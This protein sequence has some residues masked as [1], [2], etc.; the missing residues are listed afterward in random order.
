MGD[1]NPHQNLP[2]IG[3][4]V[5]YNWVLYPSPINNHQLPKLNCTGELCFSLSAMSIEGNSNISD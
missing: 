2:T 4:E 1:F 3:E 5:G